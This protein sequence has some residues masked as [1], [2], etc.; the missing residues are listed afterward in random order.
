MQGI[1]VPGAVPEPPGVN[2]GANE[3]SV[4]VEHA[5]AERDCAEAKVCTCSQDVS[6]LSCQRPTRCRDGA[7]K[8]PALICA[9]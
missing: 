1:A 5:H 3:H 6:V 4:R 8:H 7:T 2:A 9:S